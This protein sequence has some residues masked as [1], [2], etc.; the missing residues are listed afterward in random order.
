MSLSFKSFRAIP[1]EIQ[2]VVN[3]ATQQ[4]T[5]TISKATEQIKSASAFSPI[6]QIST[7]IRQ[8][9]P[10][11]LTNQTILSKSSLNLSPNPKESFGFYLGAFEKLNQLSYLTN[12]GK[13]YLSNLST[14]SDQ[15]QTLGQ[16]SLYNNITI[17]ITTAQMTTQGISLLSPYFVKQAVFDKLSFYQPEE[18]QSAFDSLLNQ[19]TS[20]N[21]QNLLTD[22][23]KITL[24]KLQSFAGSSLSVLE[25]LDLG[26]TSSDVTQDTLIDIIISLEEQGTTVFD[27][28]VWHVVTN[29]TELFETS[30]DQL[31]TLY[32]EGT[33]TPQGI[34]IFQNVSSFLN[35]FPEFSNTINLALSTE[36]LT[37]DAIFKL[38][39][40]VLDKTTWYSVTEPKSAFTTLL[41]K[42][43]S[44][45]AKNMLSTAGKDAK[46]TLSS[47]ISKWD[48][49]SS[50]G[51]TDVVGFALTTD[52][53]LLEGTVQLVKEATSIP[54]TSYLRDALKEYLVYTLDPTQ[55]SYDVSLGVIEKERRINQITHEYLASKY[56]DYV[57]REA[58]I[59]EK[60]QEKILDFM[61]GTYV[62]PEAEDVINP[63]LIAGEDRTIDLYEILDLE[64]FLN[65]GN[66]PLVGFVFQWVKI[67]G[68]GEVAFSDETSLVTQAIFS[69][70]GDYI[71]RIR[72]INTQYSLFLD[73]ELVVLVTEAA[74]SSSSNSS[75]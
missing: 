7:V 69:E 3:E 64:A 62:F 33:L 11:Y 12:D 59:A 65:G 74:S 14:L 28:A 30:F 21:E 32:N 68:P 23:G 75:I 40:T 39:P 54:T 17:G 13:N 58:W 20:Y 16:D 49:I 22:D 27:N 26:L 61:L 29:A 50:Y 52:H 5:D 6:D 2:N 15:I 48:T 41:N 47:F 51:V 53:T 1:S 18:L 60:F 67:S 9:S 19:F 63:V 73:D 72:A 25:T 4:L 66:I 46:D 35:D 31:T 45:D 43:N 34:T 42:F 70:V 71:L 10:A 37:T 56:D 38:T 57:D 8:V 36:H 24:Q 44:L 55:L